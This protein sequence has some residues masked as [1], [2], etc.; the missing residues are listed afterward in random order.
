MVRDAFKIKYWKKLRL[1]T[2]QGGEGVRPPL[3]FDVK[4]I[5][6]KVQPFHL[7]QKGGGEPRLNFFIRKNIFFG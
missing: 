1:L 5:M 2:E 4:K 6:S 7:I 3:N